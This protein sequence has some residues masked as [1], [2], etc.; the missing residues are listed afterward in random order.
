MTSLR[1][2]A[3]Y[4]IASLIVSTLACEVASSPTAL[5]TA[6]LNPSGILSTPGPAHAVTESP[7][8]GATAATL[9]PLHT[10]P[11]NT[12][13]PVPKDIQQIWMVDE[14]NGWAADASNRLY[15][16][17]DGGEGW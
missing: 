10:V 13:M 9:T 17:I 8:A 2:G 7:G 3:T 12:P 4:V 5:P 11:T 1:R 6:S 16:T 14:S 15:R